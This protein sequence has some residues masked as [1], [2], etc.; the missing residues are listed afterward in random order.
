MPPFCEDKALRTQYILLLG[1]VT[2]GGAKDIFVDLHCLAQSLMLA[3]VR[4]DVF[5]S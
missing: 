3:L 4:C 2:A 5:L 1:K